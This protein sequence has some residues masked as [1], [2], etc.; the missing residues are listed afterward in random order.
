MKALNV[1]FP[2]HVKEDI[3]NFAE[4]LGVSVSKLSRAALELGVAELKKFD[5]SYPGYAKKVIN[6]TK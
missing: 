4:S 5:S 1:R 3:D 2:D 6:A